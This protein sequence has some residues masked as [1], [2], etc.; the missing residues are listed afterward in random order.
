MASLER[1]ESCCP[2]GSPFKVSVHPDNRDGEKECL[3]SGPALNPE[4]KFTL[5]Q[6][7]DFT[8][9]AT[10]SPAGQL[11]VSAVCEQNSVSARVIMHQYRQGFYQVTIVV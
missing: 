7:V 3:L 2:V 1:C 4:V 6:P 11:F 8:V 10:G 5:G 9:D